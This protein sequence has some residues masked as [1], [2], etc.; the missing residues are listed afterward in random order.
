MSRFLYLEDGCTLKSREIVFANA[1][2]CPK[3]LTI[4]LYCAWWRKLALLKLAT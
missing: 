4:H 1:M 3:S 2:C